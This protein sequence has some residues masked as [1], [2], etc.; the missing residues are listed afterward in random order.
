MRRAIL[1][2]L[3]TSIVYFFIWIPWRTSR[4]NF[5]LFLGFGMIQIAAVY[6]QDLRGSAMAWDAPPL[7]MNPFVS[8]FV[9][10]LA[11][12]GLGTELVVGGRSKAL[13]VALLLPFPPLALA[14]YVF[15]RTN[16]VR[17]FFV[18]IVLLMLALV[19]KIM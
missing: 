11:V 16:P 17:P 6:T 1:F 13:W 19:L 15:P 12:V 2:L 8:L 3:A 10:S 4:S 18:G 9:S 5:L 7:F 14:T